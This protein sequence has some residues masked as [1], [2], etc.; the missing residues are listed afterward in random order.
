M[1]VTLRQGMLRGAF[2]ETKDNPRGRGLVALLGLLLA[3]VALAL[4]RGIDADPVQGWS[5]F[6]L[7]L[8]SLTMVGRAFDSTVG[9]GP[10]RAL[11]VTADGPVWMCAILLLPPETL[12]LLV[13][14]ASASRS[15]R[16]EK[17]LWNTG[18]H[19]LSAACSA[20]TY[21]GIQGS[22]APDFADG[23][24]WQAL[25]AMTAA[26]LVYWLTVNSLFAYI[27]VVTTGC[28]IRESG[29]WD[30]AVMPRDIAELGAGVVAAVLALVSPLLAIVVLPVFV[31]HLY[32]MNAIG[33]GMDSLNDTKTGLLT[34]AAFRAGA[35]RE[36][37][38]CQRVHEPVAVVMIDLDQFRRLN[39][40]FGHLVG[41]RVLQTVAD[42]VKRN[43][44]G[45]DLAGRFGGEEFVVLLASASESDAER[46]AERIRIELEQS[47]L[48]SSGRAVPVTAS[49]GVTEVK[50]LDDLDRA[51]QRADEALYEAKRG[52]RNRV[53]IAP[54]TGGVVGSP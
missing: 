3:V 50:G 10:G 7:A 39:E 43:L 17:T 30:L 35:A 46:V 4:L 41:D 8:L 19:L 49:M 9:A 21:W 14:A 31:L 1:T 40:E 13:V 38:R 18:A 33:K 2:D 51:I 24:D 47:D 23:P 16:W 15:V 53:L 12:I 32:S 20:A 26:V 48:R 42:I 45:F 25:V 11:I 22:R 29:L 34:L 54:S 36:L 6:L 27:Q 5:V 37:A 44:R 52:G 28:S